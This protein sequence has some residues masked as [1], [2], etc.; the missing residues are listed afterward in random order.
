[1]VSSHNR[2]CLSGLLVVLVVANWASVAQAQWSRRGR[3]LGRRACRRAIRLRPTV[4]SG[5]A[6]EVAEEQTPWRAL[7]NGKSL[8]GWR[9]AQFGGEG[10][11]SV[12]DG[13]ILM[14][15]GDSLT[16]VT[17]QG[18]D[19]PKTNYEL[20][21]E[22]KRV[23]GIDFFCGLTFPVAESHCSFIVGGWAGSVVG[24]SSIDG[25]DASEN[26]TTKYMDFKT[27][28]W[29]RLRVRVS[30]AKIQAWIDDEQVVDQRIVGRKIGTRVEV[31]LSKPLGVS[32]WQT[33]AALRNI[34]VRRLDSP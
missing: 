20:R 3:V 26:D 19:L 6:T 13:A 11:I 18:N 27:D 32:A 21:L 16:G 8:A 9:S 22:A 24:L 2:L 25:L 30:Q 29:Y 1:M 14:E 17:Y 31:D 34:E 4:T 10:Q 5:V 28:R 12:Q 7:F 23:D 15:F 33:K